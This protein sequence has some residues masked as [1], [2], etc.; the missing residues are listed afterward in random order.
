[1][2]PKI[3]YGFK[4]TVKSFGKTSLIQSAQDQKPDLELCYVSNER[5]YVVCSGEVLM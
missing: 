4:A 1:M 3:Y 2:L 5:L